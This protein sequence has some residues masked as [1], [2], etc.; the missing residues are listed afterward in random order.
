[1][2]QNESII[3]RINKHLET[4]METYKFP[5]TEVILEDMVNFGF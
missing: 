2:T 3:G 4:A 5:E 1:M